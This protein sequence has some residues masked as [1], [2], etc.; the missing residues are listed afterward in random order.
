MISCPRVDAAQQK[1]RRRHTSTINTH[2]AKNPPGWRC[3]SPTGE[4]SKKRGPSRTPRSHQHFVVASHGTIP[5]IRIWARD[6]PFGRSSRGRRV[7]VLWCGWSLATAECSQSPESEASAQVVAHWFDGARR[8]PHAGTTTREERSERRATT[9]SLITCP[10]PRR[11]RKLS[12]CRF[13]PITRGANVL[14]SGPPGETVRR[15]HPR[16]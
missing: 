16:S 3:R 5:L 11:A 12:L 1:E 4:R 13:T 10:K 2:N 6:T 15:L 7:I 9:E 14:A 8:R